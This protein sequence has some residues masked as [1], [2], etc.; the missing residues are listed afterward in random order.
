MVTCKPVVA[1]HKQNHQLLFPINTLGT[2]SWHISKIFNTEKDQNYSFTFQYCCSQ[3]SNMNMEVN[4]KSIDHSIYMVVPVTGCY[5]ITNSHL[6]PPPS[7]SWAVGCGSWVIQ[8]ALSI[9]VL[10]PPSGSW[11]VGHGW[12]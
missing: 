11:V 8:A 3:F 7:G 9:L 1:E 10:P 6:L 2:F 4:G 5:A 12:S